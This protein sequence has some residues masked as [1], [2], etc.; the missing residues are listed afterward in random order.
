MNL[1]PAQAFNAGTPLPAIAAVD[2]PH[3]DVRSG[4]ESVDPFPERAQMVQE[5]GLHRCARLGCAGDQ[6]K[7]GL[8]QNVDLGAAGFA[9]MEQRWPATTVGVVFVDFAGHPAFENRTAQRMVTQLVGTANAEQV[10][11]E[12]RVK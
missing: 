12:A 7:S 8:Q 9:V 6:I 11:G 10:T 1:P 5:V 3:F 4:R 2:K